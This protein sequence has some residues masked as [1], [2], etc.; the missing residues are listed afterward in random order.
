M[1][2]VFVAAIAVAAIP[3]LLQSSLVQKPAFE[4]TSVKPSAPAGGPL[5]MGSRGGRFTATNVPIKLLVQLAYQPPDGTGLLPDQIVGG[6]SWLASD[7]FDIEAKPEGDARNVPL[8]Q[9]WPMLQTLLEDRFQLKTHRE[10]RQ[11]P[12][13]NLI[14]AKDGLNMKLSEDQTPAVA[15][16][17]APPLNPNAPAQ[18]DPSSKPSE[19]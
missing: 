13:Y 5:T 10:T 9:M 4:V 2:Y 18:P 15:D 14:I 8:G 11:L 12:V 7:H 3:L 6:P 17:D 19:N 16:P 1:R